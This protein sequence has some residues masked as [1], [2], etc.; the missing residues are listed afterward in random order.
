MTERFF[1]PGGSHSMKDGSSPLLCL[2]TAVVL[3]MASAIVACGGGSKPTPTQGA[4]VRSPTAAVSATTEASPAIGTP[5]TVATAPA[6]SLSGAFY[7]VDFV[8]DSVGWAAGAAG[9]FGTTDAGLRWHLQLANDPPAESGQVDFLDADTGFA[10]T[11]RGLMGTTDGGAHW[12]SYSPT[13]E[14]Q[15]R[16]IDFVSATRGWGIAST[17]RG[18]TTDALFRIDIVDGAA[19]YTPVLP[20]ADSVCFGDAADGWA[21]NGAQVMHTTDSG[22]TWTA[23]FDNPFAGGGGA[24]WIAPSLRCVGHNTAWVLF[25]DGVAAGN[26]AYAS[27]A[28]NDAGAHWAPM[29]HGGMGPSVGGHTTAGGYPGPISVLD[30]ADDYVVTSCTACEEGT[31]A[32]EVTH[33]GGTTWSPPVDIDG[34]GAASF[35]ASLDFISRDHGWLASRGGI[36]ATSDGGATWV[37]QR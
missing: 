35:G 32:I 11:G 9:I 19:L 5:A 36:F 34:A 21:A 37:R 24:A 30:A 12:T 26:E 33:D 1:I 27:F 25:T 13:G 18:S 16:A 28:T 29:T 3:A 31:S 20:V 22:A 10:L 6:I 14:G 7:S 23:P 2:F 4:V 17:E 15:P 8:S